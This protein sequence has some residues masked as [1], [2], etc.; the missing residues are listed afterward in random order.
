[1]W[2]EESVAMRAGEEEEVKSQKKSREPKYLYRTDPRQGT[3]GPVETLT[4]GIRHPQLPYQTAKWFHPID[5]SIS[6][7]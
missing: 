2:S 1:M 5:F 3:C 7:E 6:D 4:S